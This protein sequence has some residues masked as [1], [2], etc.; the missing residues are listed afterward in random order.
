MNDPLQHHD[1]CERCHRELKPYQSVCLTNGNRAEHLC[2]DCYNEDAARR[3]GIDKPHADFLPLTLRDADG[4]KHTFHFRT[5]LTTGLGITAYEVLGGEPHDDGYRFMVL[6]HPETEPMEA[7]RKLRNKIRKGLSRKCLIERE[8]RPQSFMLSDDALVLGRI[9]ESEDA[10]PAIDVIIDGKRFSWEELGHIIAPNIGSNFKLAVYDPSDDIPDEARIPLEK[11][12]FWLDRLEGKQQG[13][14]SLPEPPA[15]DELIE[16][17]RR[18]ADMENSGASVRKIAAHFRITSYRLKE[19]VESVRARA[20]RTDAT[21]KLF[22]HIRL[23]DDLDARWPKKA[24][25]DIL[26]L[27]GDARLPFSFLLQRCP[28]E[29][30]NLKDLMN[31][32]I[33]DVISHDTGIYE[34]QARSRVKGLGRVRYDK[35]IHAISRCDFGP[36]FQK[37]WERRK[38]ALAQCLIA[39]GCKSWAFSIFE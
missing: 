20:A 18:V 17:D 30:M 37:E 33:A 14:E 22:E 26:A 11:K 8:D 19:V 34:A 16:R 23:L 3:W 13:H 9:A 35:I 24:L 15:I 6:M 2:N 12:L 39:N 31:L 25:T 27:P 29:E 4:K 32:L 38:K 28:T 5:M 1:R 36:A 10:W 7:F 21:M